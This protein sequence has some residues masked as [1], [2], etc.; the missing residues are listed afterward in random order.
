M[1]GTIGVC[2]SVCAVVGA[3]GAVGI[4][5]VWGLRRLWFPFWCQVAFVERHW[6]KEG[7]RS[8]VFVAKVA[9]GFVFG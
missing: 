6:L 1:I 9:L 5:V 3:G 8:C 7:Q 4:L 2:P